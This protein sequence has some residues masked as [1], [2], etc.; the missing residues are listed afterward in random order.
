MG[1]VVSSTERITWR[2][3]DYT[4]GANHALVHVN[5]NQI[6]LR[7]LKFL[8]SEEEA[9]HE[10]PMTWEVKGFN[11]LMITLNG[12]TVKAKWVSWDKK[13]IMGV[14]GMPSVLQYMSWIT[15][16]EAAVVRNRPRQSVEAPE[17]PHPL[18]PGKPG[19]LVVI[20]GPPGAG[21]STTAGAI[22]KKGDWVYYEGD[23]FLNGF[24]PYLAPNENQVAARSEK[25]A[26][27]GPG[28]AQR[29]KVIKSFWDDQDV[30]GTCYKLMAEDIKK[31]RARV[32][33]NFVVAMFCQRGGRDIFREVLNDVIFVVLDIPYDLV[34]ARLRRREDDRNTA[35]WLTADHGRFEQ[36]QNYEPRILTFTITKESTKEQNADAIL[37][38]INKANVIEH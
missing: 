24:N 6:S 4:V 28:M 14:P 13:M 36:A 27:F 2:D 21:K 11:S 30:D 37:H 9:E 29:K 38:L 26:L 17:V 3:G 33:G 31:E 25:A 34:K 22:A 32:G 35:D 15:P 18:N 10:H 20:T 1:C 16:E 12:E 19:K 8:E 23:G 5:G 7:F